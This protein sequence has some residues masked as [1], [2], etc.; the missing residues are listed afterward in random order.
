MTILT[1]AQKLSK[2]VE[3]CKRKPKRQ[4]ATCIKQAHKRYG[5]AANK[6]GK[7]KKK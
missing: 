7:G 3:A 4:R 1:N 2:A 5:P 6:K